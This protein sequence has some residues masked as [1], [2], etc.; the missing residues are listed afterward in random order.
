MSPIRPYEKKKYHKKS[1]KDLSKLKP[2]VNPEFKKRN[3][4]L[5]ETLVDNLNRNTT[6]KREPIV[7]K[8]EEE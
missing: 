2:V 4:E 3:D 6:K 7:S 8:P 5:F 1:T